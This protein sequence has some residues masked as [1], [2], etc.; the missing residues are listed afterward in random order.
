MGLVIITALIALSIY[1]VI[2]IPYSE[3]MRLWRGGEDIWIENPRNA[4]PSWVNFFLKERLP[5]TI[6]VESQPGG[7]S[8][9]TFIWRSAGSGNGAPFRLPLRRLPQ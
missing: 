8:R 2:A 6:I 4:R 3:G 7:E 5:Q 9:T 1:T